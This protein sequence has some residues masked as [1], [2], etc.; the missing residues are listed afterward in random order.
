M[1]IDNLNHTGYDFEKLPV[2][3]IHALNV[4]VEIRNVCGSNCDNKLSVLDLEIFKAIEVVDPTNER[5]LEVRQQLEFDKK[6][7]SNNSFNTKGLIDLGKTE[8]LEMIKVD[9]M[10]DLSTSAQRDLYNDQG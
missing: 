5:V 9:N 3:I 7:D 6:Q 1:L 4:F 2:E 8:I 10:V